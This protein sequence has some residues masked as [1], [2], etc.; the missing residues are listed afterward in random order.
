MRSMIDSMPGI[1]GWRVSHSSGGGTSGRSTQ[2][3]SVGDSRVPSAALTVRISVSATWPTTRP[4]VTL[5]PW[6]ASVTSM[7]RIDGGLA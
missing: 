4:C 5:R 6:A 1:R 3:P 2:A 7:S